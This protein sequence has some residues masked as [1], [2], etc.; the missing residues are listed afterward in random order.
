MAQPKQLKMVVHWTCR[1]VLATVFI[2]SGA[3]KATDVASFTDAVATFQLLPDGLV[4]LTATYIPWL[5]VVVGVAILVPFAWRGANLIL[6]V[7]LLTFSAALE[8]AIVRGIDIHCG[9]FGGGGD[10]NAWTAL[11]RNVVLLA[12]CATTFYT[13]HVATSEPKNTLP[14]VKP[15]GRARDEEVVC[16]PLLQR[17]AR[18]ST[19]Q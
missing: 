2:Y 19:S 4:K 15:D 8:T 10:T 7:L 18:G 17:P 9:C 6:F 14:L 16:E 3:M 13:R 5:E 1:V 12:V 11:L